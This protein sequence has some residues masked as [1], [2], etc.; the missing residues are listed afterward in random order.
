MQTSKRRSRN[1][2]IMQLTSDVGEST[3]KINSFD[4]CLKRDRSSKEAETRFL[5]KLRH[6]A[7]TIGTNKRFELHCGNWT[8]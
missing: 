1:M 7:R 5:V 3:N 6:N 2:Q 8:H 4:R